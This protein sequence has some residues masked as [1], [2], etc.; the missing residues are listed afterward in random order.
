MPAPSIVLNVHGGIVQDVFASDPDVEV[1]LVDW[2]VDGSDAAHPNVVAITDSLGRTRRAYVSPLA[3]EPLAELIGSDV[4]T[5]I[6]VANFVG[7]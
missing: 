3:V 1:T 4:E 2:D 6:E 5:A 7:C